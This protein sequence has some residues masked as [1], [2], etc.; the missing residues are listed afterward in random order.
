MGRET[1]ND[2]KATENALLGLSKIL[3]GLF[4]RL[5]SY[6]V[7]SGMSMSVRHSMPLDALATILDATYFSIAEKCKVSAVCKGWRGL[8]LGSVELWAHIS[9]SPFQSLI[10]D[11]VVIPLITPARCESLVTL[12]LNRC[13]QLTASCF[14]HVLSQAIFNALETLDLSHCEFVNDTTLQHIV[15]RCPKLKFL[16]LNGLSRYLR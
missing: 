4:M 1:G 16:G 2:R 15:E 5:S 13:R 11:S 7:A 10:N 9:F 8:V 6:L 3:I 12:D 14:H